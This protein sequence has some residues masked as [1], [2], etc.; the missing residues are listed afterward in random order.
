MKYIKFTFRKGNKQ[1]SF[2]KYKYFIESRPPKST[3]S[4][5]TS[6]SF[7][8]KKSGEPEKAMFTKEVIEKGDEQYRNF[9][10]DH[11]S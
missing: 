4:S 7:K 5:T 9:N 8:S 3:S 6:S 10:P 11:A 2:I 1:V